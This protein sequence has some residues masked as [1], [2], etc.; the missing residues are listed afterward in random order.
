MIYLA[1]KYSHP[2]ALQRR[3]NFLLAQQ[4]IAALLLKTSRAVFSPIVYAHDM[5]E[6]FK[7]P[8]DAEFWSRFDIEILRHCEELWQLYVPGW[9]T[10]LGCMEE[11]RVATQLGLP[12]RFVNPDGEF[13]NP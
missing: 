8:T 9:E 6:R 1:S 12:I 4:T 11:H 10:S 13:V 7:L 2:D 5:A 3:T